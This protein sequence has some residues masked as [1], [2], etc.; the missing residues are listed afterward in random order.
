MWRS[1]SEA[2]TKCGGVPVR[3]ACPREA[4]MKPTIV[5]PE[6]VDTNLQFK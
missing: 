2:G 1:A 4:T 3:Q 5:S 6:Y